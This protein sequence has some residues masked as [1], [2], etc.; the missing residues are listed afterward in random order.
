MKSEMSKLSCAYWRFIFCLLTNMG[1]ILTQFQ[2]KVKKKVLYKH[3]NSAV[4]QAAEDKI[5]F[6]GKSGVG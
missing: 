2:I 4:L 5:V 6:V 1:G 3:I